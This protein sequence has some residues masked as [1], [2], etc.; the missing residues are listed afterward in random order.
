M[1]IKVLRAETLWQQTGAYHVRIEGMNRRHHISLRDEFDEHD[2]SE[3]KYI[4]LL[5]DEYPVAT[6]RIYELDPS[7]AMIGRVVVLPD[8]R[9]RGLGRMV[10]SEGEKWC[11]DLG[12]STVVIE[13]RT[14]AI[15][16][17]KKLG[18]TVRSDQLIHGPTFTCVEMEKRL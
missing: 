1:D 9:G 4:V 10:M 7:S 12:Y 8:Y 5:D 6:C 17:Y 11:R 14:T 18:F 3:T 15:D 2:T 13:S 16:F